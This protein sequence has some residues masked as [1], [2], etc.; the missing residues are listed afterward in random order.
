MKILIGTNNENKL[1]QFRRMFGKFMPEAEVYSLGDMNI[2]DD[3]E[4]DGETL[5]ENATKK[6]KYFG[7]KSGIITLADDT[8][9][10]VDVLDGEPG[11]HAKRWHAGTEKER[12]L[13]LI[14]KLKNISESERTCRYVGVLAIYN[15]KNKK[16]WTYEGKVEGWISDEF[17]GTSGF[18]YDQIFKTKAYDGR[19]YA[20][21][22]HAEKDLI[23]HRGMGIREF[24]KNKDKIT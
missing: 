8:G 1:R 24:A 2:T 21:L 22:D 17:K 10:F 9:L 11:V 23:S 19:H 3:V 12:N 6:A 4:E 13:K 5:F 20:E 18:G 16:S 7:E 15:P 14:E